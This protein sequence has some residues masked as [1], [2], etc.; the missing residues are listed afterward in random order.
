[1][2]RMILG[3]DLHVPHATL[4]PVRL[5]LPGLGQQFDIVEFL[6]RYATPYS[7]SGL[8]LRRAPAIAS[9]LVTECPVL[10]RL[11]VAEHVRTKQS[12]DVIIDGRDRSSLD[13]RGP[14]KAANFLPGLPYNRTSNSHFL[15]SIRPAP[16]SI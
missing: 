2:V 13:H 14:N 12:R 11:V 7:G 8:D 10:V 3:L 15:I 4:A 6:Q 5:C 9:V 16:A 1:M